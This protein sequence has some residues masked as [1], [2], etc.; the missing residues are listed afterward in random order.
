M[1]KSC[2]WCHETFTCGRSDQRMCSDKCR[3]RSRN[4]RWRERHHEAELERNRRYRED[5]PDYFSQ[6][7]KTRYENDREL[8]V[9]Q[10]RQYRADNPQA[11][12]EIRARSY[13]KHADK[14]RERS[15]QY[16]KANPEQH[17]LSRHNYM[18]KRRENGGTFSYQEWVDLKAEHDHRCL[19]CGK[20]ESD[21]KLSVDHIIPISLG[22]KHEKDNIQP[23]CVSCNARK[24]TKIVDYR[25]ASATVQI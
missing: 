21:I 1:R 17:K 11:V 14:N 20:Q 25:P 5:N 12:I 9:G 16:R 13:E 24:R 7:A 23:L 8:F 18:A 6:H 2:E 10:A 4:K 19:R 22:G 3:S 15:R